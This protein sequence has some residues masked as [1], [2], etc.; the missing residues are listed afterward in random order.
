[1][2]YLL[3]MIKIKDKNINIPKKV[4]Y[5]AE[6]HLFNANDTEQIIEGFEYGGYTLPIELVNGIWT[7]NYATLISKSINK[8]KKFC[9]NVVLNSTNNYFAYII[10]A[11]VKEYAK[12]LSKREWEYILENA[13]DYGTV[14]DITNIFVDNFENII[15]KKLSCLNYSV[16]NKNNKLIK[17]KLKILDNKETR[18]KVQEITLHINNFKKV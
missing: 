9:N 18:Q 11:D 15:L 3:E 16:I 4:Y 5:F 7:E 13:T 17:N 6:G 14:K 8:V 2:M 12:Y 1:M 10:E